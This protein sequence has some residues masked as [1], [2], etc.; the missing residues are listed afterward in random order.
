MIDTYE[1][2]IGTYCL[3]VGANLIA[4]AHNN[5]SSPLPLQI[6]NPLDPNE[7]PSKL[8]MEDTTM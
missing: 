3:L 7:E 1:A 4:M 2:N 6:L 5:Q 8:L